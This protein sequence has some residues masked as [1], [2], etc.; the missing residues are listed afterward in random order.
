MIRFFIYWSFLFLSI[1][2]IAQKDTIVNNNFDS[3]KGFKIDAKLIDANLEFDVDNKSKD[4]SYLFYSKKKPL[5][6]SYKINAKKYLNPNAPKRNFM[7]GVKPLDSDVLVV[8]YF[9]G[10]NNSNKSFK[11]TQNLGTI[12]SN[13]EFVRIE[14]KD[15]G[16][17]DGDRVQVFLNER[18]VNANVALNGL[19]YTLHIKLEKKGYNKIDIKAINQGYVGPNTAEFIVYDDKG[20]VIAHE[21]WN[22][23]TDEIAT[24][25]IIKF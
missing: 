16:L 4:I 17:V 15:F 11:T 21:A 2:M 19:Y 10:K 6:L 25:G 3:S 8:K 12:Q 9:D 7:F 13:T 24:L 1:V 22:L 14:Y 20:N 18:E 23:K 5:N